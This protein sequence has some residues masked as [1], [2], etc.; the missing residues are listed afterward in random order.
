MSTD[1]SSRRKEMDFMKLMNGPRKVHPSD[2]VSEFWVEFCGP[3][4]TPYED[5]VW[6]I[7]VQLPAEYPFK[8]PSIGFSNR[9]FHPNV[10]ESSGSVCLDVINQTWTPMYELHNIFDVFLPQLL[11]YPN[12]SDPLN[13]AAAS[14]LIHDPIG[15]VTFVQD[16]VAEYAT[17]RVALQSIPSGFRPQGN[18][19]SSAAEV[20]NN[21]SSEEDST[22]TPKGLTEITTPH[23]VSEGGEEEE[24]EPDAIDI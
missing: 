11:R 21:I 14:K 15:Y 13:S 17:R 24:Y 9:I 3:E 18:G 1:R 19:A 10:D 20:K 5:G 6:Y 23:V 2:S 7:H 16:H 22:A 4:G 12:A 8:S